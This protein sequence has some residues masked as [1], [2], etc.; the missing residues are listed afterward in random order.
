MSVSQVANLPLPTLG[1]SSYAV[2]YVAGLMS[3][4]YWQRNWLI[5]KQGRQIRLAGEWNTMILVMTLFW[6]NFSLGFIQAVQPDWLATPAVSLVLGSVTGFAAGNF[7]G[8]SLRVVFSHD[9]APE[10]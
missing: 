9:I 6:A 3:G 10:R 8:S 1:W 4:F 2:C 7:L 5:S